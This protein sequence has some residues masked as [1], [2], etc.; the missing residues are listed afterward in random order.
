MIQRGYSKK[1]GL[2]VPDPMNYSPI[3]KSLHFDPS[4]VAG[5]IPLYADSKKN[6]RCVETS[7]FKEFW[8][9]QFDRCINGYETGGIF[10]PGRYYF[11]LNFGTITG[12]YGK[13]YPWYLDI[14]LEFWR[15]VE[16]ARAEHKLGVV[17]PKARRRGI[18]EMIQI[19]EMNYGLR[20]IEGFKGAVAA[21]DNKYIK[22]FR[23]RLDY[24]DTEIRDELKLNYLNNNKDEIKIGY[25][26]LNAVNQK[27]ESGFG[28]MLKFASMYDK[29]TKLEGEYFHS[30]DC[31]ESGQFPLVI[32]AIESIK[33]ALMM[34]SVRKGIFFICGTGGNI[35]SSSKGFKMA[36]DQADTLD[37]IQFYVSG[38]RM[39]YPF[40]GL[41]KEVLDRHNATVI[42]EDEKLI[43]NLPNLSKLGWTQEELVGC[44]DIVASE[45]WILDT[46]EEYS[47]L[48]NKKNLIKHKQ[49]FPITVQDCF[50]S[51]GSNDFNTGLLMMQK[52]EIY[53]NDNDKFVP[54]DYVIEW[55]KAKDKYG[56]M[57]IKLPLKVEMRVATKSDKEWEVVR[58]LEPP[59]SKKSKL[60]HIGV[61]AYEMDETETSS[62][63]GGICVLRDTRKSNHIGLMSRSGIYPIC[64]YYSRPPRKEYFFDLCLKISVLYGCKRRS[65]LS[66]EHESCIDHFKKSGGES[67]LAYR[68]KAL[69]SPKSKLVHKYGT[70]MTPY[71][72]PRF[73]SIM[74]SY[75]EDYSDMIWFEE[76]IDDYLTYDKENM[77]NDWDLADACGN[78][79]TSL[80]KKSANGNSDDSYGDEEVDEEN[81]KEYKKFSN[82]PV[83]YYDRNGKFVTDTSKMITPG[84]DKER[85][86][87]PDRE[88]RSV[89]FIR[90]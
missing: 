88:S 37:L 16:Y 85:E 32:D 1:D 40:I 42:S 70:K 58:I 18:T 23:D 34:G 52:H 84:R 76:L 71:S 27:E 64:V 39:L 61:D 11:F 5:N 9:E 79:L 73:L 80:L 63:L 30:V 74:Q 43:V 7:A 87:G 82:M 55:E 67:Y 68:P 59:L 33:P 2:W 4:P 20:F 47:K 31:E 81:E 83:Y 38:R 45:K 44:E 57:V 13:Q 69:D 56:L 6:P 46:I 78:A 50:T 12:V 8:D 10:I 48:P 15:T 75:I 28:G 19:G 25:E 89:D 17:V 21:G 90:C 49:S 26:I 22:V 77:G 36:W 35:L 86:T 41:S 66:A 53:K 3:R 14:Q 24:T 62:S 72:K 29:A 54:G 51:G 60:D 65:M